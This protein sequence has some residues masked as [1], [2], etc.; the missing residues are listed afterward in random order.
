MDI[1]RDNQEWINY[2]ETLKNKLPAVFPRYHR[3]LPAFVNRAIDHT[4]LAESATNE[5]VDTLCAEAKARR[6]A[7]VCVRPQH[8][9]RA[10]QNLRGCNDISV[11]C[12]VSFPDGTNATADKAN[13]AQEAL[14]HGASELDMV[15]NYPQLAEGRYMEIYHDIAAV[16]NV[17]PDPVK[18]KVIIETSQL[19]RDEVIA[20]SL[21]AALSGAEF[22]KTSTGFKGQGA[23][24]DNVQLMRAVADLTDKGTKVK[25]SGGIRSAEECV[26]MLRAGADRIGASSGVK[27]MEQLDQGEMMEQGTGHAVY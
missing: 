5:Q 20:G 23:T 7:T 24:E 9:A 8:V 3:P 16:R 17:A 13:E 15:M 18:L 25:A 21:V 22:V 27:I 19:S 12:V 6:F 2:I 10:A 4:L 11:A 14:Q 1:P 26:R